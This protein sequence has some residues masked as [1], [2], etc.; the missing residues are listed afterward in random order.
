MAFP[1]TK[2]NS[3]LGMS[4]VAAIFSRSS[5]FG[6]FTPLSI[7]LSWLAERFNCSA[8]C[9]WVILLSL[10][11]AHPAA[12]RIF[13]HHRSSPRYTSCINHFD[14]KAVIPAIIGRKPPIFLFKSFILSLILLH[15][16]LS[17]PFS[18][19]AAPAGQYLTLNSNVR[20]FT[21][22]GAICTLEAAGIVVQLANR[23][24]AKICNVSFT[25]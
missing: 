24:T 15:K 11:S 1:G 14:I 16:S 5:G 4:S 23:K 3:S 25:V 22:V 20:N 7:L 19:A 9:C 10:L 6:S 8:S 2:K 12:E 18:A 21:G 13:C 17:F